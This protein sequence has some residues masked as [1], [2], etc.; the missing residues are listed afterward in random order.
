MP[1]AMAS[2]SSL[3]A[4]LC[5]GSLR[6]TRREA[7]SLVEQAAAANAALS[8]H[9]SIIEPTFEPRF[10]LVTTDRTRLAGASGARPG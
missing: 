2:C 5:V 4:T 1:W 8:E 6:N 7:A 10:P 3:T 9:A